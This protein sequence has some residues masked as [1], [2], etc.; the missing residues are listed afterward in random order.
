MGVVGAL[1]DTQMVPFKNGDYSIL[2][3]FL[4]DQPKIYLDDL[5]GSFQDTLSEIEICDLHLKVRSRAS[6][7]FSY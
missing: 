7:N 5:R 1:F 2:V 3:L 4:H 6:P